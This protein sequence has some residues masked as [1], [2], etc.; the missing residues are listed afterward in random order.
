MLTVGIMIASFYNCM[1]CLYYLSII[2]FNKKDDYIKH[3][4]EP[5]FHGVP[6]ILTIVIGIAGLIMKQYNT[7]GTA[8]VCHPTSYN[9]PH[10]EGGGYENSIIPKVM[11]I[12]NIVPV[13]IIPAII[14]GTIV[15]MY[16]TMR[17]I[18]RK[19]QYYGAG[20]LRLRCAHQQQAQE[21]NDP[22]LTLTLI[23]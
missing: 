7:D 1:I 15:I 19:M 6:I 18:E 5:W 12:M 9:P 10:C 20:A 14:V 4:L 2:T 13:T 3:K 22:T 23:F 21:V 17:K 16:R 8:G 11:L